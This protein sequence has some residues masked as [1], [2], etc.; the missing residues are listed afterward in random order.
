MLKFSR[1]FIGLFEFVDG[2][3]DCLC[4]LWG[5]E[6]VFGGLTCV[7][8]GGD[9]LVLLLI[10]IEVVFEIVFGLDFECCEG[11][12]VCEVILSENTLCLQGAKRVDELR[13]G[14]L[15]FE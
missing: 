4:A 14:G 3:K 12:E 10:D 11:G 5:E 1:Q 6:E 2:F 15:V 9:V 8:E 7:L 13:D